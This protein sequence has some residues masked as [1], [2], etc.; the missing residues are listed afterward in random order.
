MKKFEIIEE[1]SNDELIIIAYS[2]F[3]DWQKE[4]V[5]YAKELLLKR[6][7][8]KNKA[9]E[10]LKEL[11]KEN[12]LLWTK[13]LVKR[14]EE[15]YTIIDFVL[16]ALF[17]FG[18]IFRDWELAKEGYVK[19]RRQ[20]LFA[21]GIGILFH[22]LLIIYA[23]FAYDIQEQERINE[24]NQTAIKDSI[25]IQKIDWSGTYVFVDTLPN[26]KQK[27]IWELIIRK[28]QGKHKAILSLA[29]KSESISIDCVGLIKPDKL[30]IFPDSTYT[31][32]NN[33][34]ISYYD[35]LFSLTRDNNDIYTTW[36]NMSPYFHSKNNGYGLFKSNPTS[37]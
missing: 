17:W 25:I 14:K 34:T 32:F 35:R 1:Y 6:G 2:E 4:A 8:T 24:I 12:E 13:E 23:S 19:M 5:A 33:Q 11:F 15:N 31:I 18:A 21:I 29:N 30:E 28:T 16:T 20:R 26:Q 10:R 36:V 27:I 7:F 22:T 37:N 9:K 3:E